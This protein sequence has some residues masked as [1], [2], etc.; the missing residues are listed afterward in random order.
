M[1]RDQQQPAP[2]SIV[3]GFDMNFSGVSNIPEKLKKFGASP[4]LSQFG[5]DLFPPRVIKS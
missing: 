1:G 5:R 3:A 2:I 4:P